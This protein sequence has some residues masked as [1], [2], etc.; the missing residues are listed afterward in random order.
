MLERLMQ[1][2]SALLLILLGLSAPS[3]G[4][5]TEWLDIN[6]FLALQQIREVRLSPDGEQVAYLLR[7]E[8]GAS[9]W[10]LDPATGERRQRLRTKLAESL[11]WA[12]D[13]QGLFVDAQ[14][15][16]AYLPANGGRASWIFQ[17]DALRE[18]EFLGVDPVL[19]HHILV[20]EK[21]D[22]E[23]YRL[24]RIDREGNVTTVYERHEEIRRFVVADDGGLAFVK[25]TVGLEQVVYRVDDDGE[26]E[27][28]R[29]HAIDP[30][31][32][33]TVDS[34]GRLLLRAALDGD[35]LQLYAVDPSTG[36]A[37]TLHRDP[38][39]LADVAGIVFKPNGDP[40]LAHHH[41]D[42]RRVYA[43]APQARGPVDKIR[44]HLPQRDLT[45][46]A[47]TGRYW[48]VT[49]RDA[50]LQHPRYHLY[51][52]VEEKLSGIL[53]DLR[54][55]IPL[56]P[57]E[58]LAEKRFISF[59][60]G[61]GMTIH[62][63]LMLP[64]AAEAEGRLRSTPL[65]AAIHGGPWNHVRSGFGPYSQFLVSRGYIVF[66]PNFRASTGFGFEYMKAANG[67]FGN[68]RVQ[69]DILDGV[70]HLL[71][72]GIGDPERV[73]IVGHSFGGF[74]ALGG[75]AFTPRKFAAGIASAPPIDLVRAFQDLDDKTLSN[76]IP[77]KLGIQELL[78]LQDK[79]ALAELRRKS[80][81]AHLGQTERPLLMFAGGRD[82]RVDIVDVKHYA[83]ALH[84]QGNDVSF[85]VDDEQGH[86]REG[87]IPT[88]AFLY[89][90]ERFLAQHLGGETR[91]VSDPRME[92][93]I[94]LNLRL[95]SA[96]LESA[97]R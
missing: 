12:P 27:V 18:Q 10:L 19:P 91:A 44:R 42:A 66:E 64:R 68:G 26:H 82:D 76:G 89:L 65:V 50:R 73:A 48:L 85:L 32:P 71:A 3:S 86:G 87:E 5:E 24:L 53:G 84:A 28:L 57:E 20:A 17:R 11:Y 58:E 75:L 88:K 8:P 16:V 33:L 93:Y 90:V 47:G 38:L 77:R 78:D 81:E 55:A 1:R 29:C 92:D 95:K 96:S 31:T 94:A 69:Q 23:T 41:S 80:P 15:R 21:A 43:V 51:D 79:A 59:E 60:A 25:G 74:S 35:L 63:F 72:Q 22:E 61:D 4:A 45:L 30:C 9:V 83:A 52:T 7:E 34:S 70:D 36:R 46:D 37:E 6:L 2:A 40:L 67:D 13:S 62:G 54:N 14:E 49:E 39:D 97:L 56:L